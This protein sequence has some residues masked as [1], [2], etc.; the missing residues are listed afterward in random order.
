MTGL[1]YLE[2]GAWARYSLA[3]ITS[4]VHRYLTS[5]CAAETLLLLTG[6]PH[7]WSIPKLTLIA[8]LNICW[9]LAAT[10]WLFH[11]IFVVV[12]WP[13]VLAT[14]A[15][16]YAAVSKLT[17]KWCR[18]IWKNAHFSKDR[19]AWFGIPSLKLDINISG[20]VTIRGVTFSLL[21]LALE[22]HGIEICE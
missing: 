8:I 22:L 21:D 18:K 17:R 2:P 16:Q 10:S 12:C 14:S 19:V 9:G 5:G 20:L 7:H 15:L 1:E 11:I 6:P 4:S 3:A 13:L